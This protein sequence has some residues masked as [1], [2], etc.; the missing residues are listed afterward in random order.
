MVRRTVVA[1]GFGRAQVS[2]EDARM[3]AA[4]GSLGVVDGAL[5]ERQG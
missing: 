3:A 5:V 4:A 2:A 1:H